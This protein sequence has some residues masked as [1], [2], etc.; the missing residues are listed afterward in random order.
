MRTVSTTDW[1]KTPWSSIYA[2]IMMKNPA[3]M[4]Q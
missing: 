3:M 4:S 2:P 1:K